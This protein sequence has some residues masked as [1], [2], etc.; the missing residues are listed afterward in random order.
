[1]STDEVCYE[2]LVSAAEA[3]AEN[4]GECREVPREDAGGH[5][6]CADIDDHRGDEH[7]EK[8]ETDG[9]CCGG[10]AD[11]DPVGQKNAGAFPVAGFAVVVYFELE[12]KPQ[13]SRR[14]E[15]GKSSCEGDTVNAH[16]RESKKSFEEYDVQ[17]CVCGNREGVADK[18]PN[19]KAMCR[20]EGG[21]DG[22]QS[23]EGKPER[24]DAQKLRG[25]FGGLIGESH[26]LR[27]V[28]GKRVDDERE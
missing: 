7:L 3:D 10:E 1:M 15:P 13:D 24:N 5:C 4:D 18:V 6:G 23:A 9:F 25:I 16:F 2:N 26:P 19:G 27:N 11:A 28:P 20:D 12:H 17:G 21:E 8:L 22:L 14:N